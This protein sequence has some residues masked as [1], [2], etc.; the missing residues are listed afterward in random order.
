MK[1]EPQVLQKYVEANKKE[2]Q[3]WMQWNGVIPVPDDE[4]KAIL[5]DF[6]LKKRVI[7]ARNAYRD[8]NRGAGPTIED[9][10]A[11]CRTVIL[12]CLDPDLSSLNRTSPTPSKFSESIVLQVACSGLNGQVENTGKLW[13]LW[14]GDVKT[15]FLQGVPEARSERLWMRPPRDGIQALAQT[16]PHRLYLIQGNLYG[17]A[18]APYTWFS[19]VANTLLQKKLVQHR[20]DKTMFLKRD[21][22]NLLLVVLIVHVDD[23]L[24]AHRED[25]DLDEIRKAFNWGS[26]T[27]LGPDNTIVFRG[28]EIKMAKQGQ[29]TTIQVTQTSFIKEMDDKPITTK[30]SEDALLTTDQWQEFRSLTGSLQWL[31]GQTRPDAAAIT[32]LSNKGRDTTVKDLK[33][34]YEF[35]KVM[36]MTE[37]LGLNVY[38]IPWNR[39]MTLVGYSDSSR[40][41][42]PGHK[43]QMGVLVLLSTPECTEKR[44]PASVLD[45]KST[46]SPR[47]TRSTLASEANA[48]DECT[49]RCVYANHFI[50]H[51]LWPDAAKDAAKMMHRQAT[52]CRSLYD[53]V[54]SPSPAL[55]EKRTIISVRSIQDFLSEQ[56]VHWVP[57]TAMWADALTKVDAEL[58]ATFQRWLAAPFVQ[59]K[60]GENKKYSSVNFSVSSLEGIRDA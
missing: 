43:S 42:A 32:S 4:A 25:Y 59:L 31:S 30:A 28:K 57:T 21:D 47:V 12:G 26:E 58:I 54:I 36:K 55:T 50:T 13:R 41:N 2:Y 56:Q 22:N 23:F 48:M 44:C 20:L 37:G 34:L 38:P 35:V 14:S 19:H 40:A 5:A 29:V 53:A 18:S 46:R 33:A 3:S 17:F 7:P 60:A 15:A 24:V 10:M 1:E 6:T 49:D 52:D 16:F 27:M 11:K 9:I 39:A 8:K 45:W 51:L